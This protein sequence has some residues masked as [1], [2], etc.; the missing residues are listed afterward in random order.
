M[1]LHKWEKKKDKKTVGSVANIKKNIILLQ[2]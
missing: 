1:F 2:L